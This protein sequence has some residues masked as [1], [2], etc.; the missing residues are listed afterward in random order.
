VLAQNPAMPT[1]GNAQVKKLGAAVPGNPA[2]QQQ[3]MSSGLKADEKQQ[4]VGVMSQPG[5]QPMAG[6]FGSA[7]PNA[8]NQGYMQPQNPPLQQVGA[9]P[10]YPQQAS[11]GT[12][13]PS[14][15]AQQGA[16]GQQGYSVVPPFNVM[17][18]QAQNA[19]VPA[20]NTGGQ[21]SYGSSQ[22]QNVG[23]QPQYA[24]VS[25][26]YNAGIAG[27]NT[28]FA[29]N[30]IAANGVGQVGRVQAASTKDI[31]P[32]KKLEVL[33]DVADPKLTEAQSKQ[34]L[35][36]GGCKVALG[37]ALDISVAKSPDFKTKIKS[38]IAAAILIQESQIQIDEVRAGS[39]KLGL[40]IKPSNPIGSRAAPSEAANK[41]ALLVQQGQLK[42]YEL[43][44]KADSCEVVLDAVILEKL[45]QTSETEFA[46]M[47]E[48]MENLAPLEA[49]LPPSQPAVDGPAPAAASPAVFAIAN[50]P[51]IIPPPTSA[52][53]P[54][55][56]YAC[57]LGTGFVGT[58][59]E[60]QAHEQRILA[61]Q[62]SGW[63]TVVAPAHGPSSTFGSVPAHASYQPMTIV[64]PAQAA[65]QPGLYGSQMGVSAQ[66][67]GPDYSMQVPQF[68]YPGLPA[69]HAFAGG[70]GT[71][72]W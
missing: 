59:D 12:G 16:T 36:D 70:P 61:A 29:Q 57:S 63:G 3:V 48:I 65:Y 67:S 46:K 18:A 37:L 20:Q 56:L 49:P 41:L 64:A 27:N 55:R 52:L 6:G 21:M 62:A 23:G 33:K 72:H 42:K 32:T 40:T 9:Q 17:P 31:P 11:F 50:Q 35:S 66:S 10:Q 69:Q 2:A 25:T 34:I 43:I 24:S 58:F 26:G 68:G 54:Q 13:Q 39:I 1:Y 71:G 30:Q 15:L 60:V 14:Y 45:Q 7:V 4:P 5:S 8:V 38:E 28:G 22:P 53:S 44:G 47:K 19:G 51:V